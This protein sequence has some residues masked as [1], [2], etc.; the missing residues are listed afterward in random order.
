MEQEVD[1]A[2]TASPY[3]DGSNYYWVLI[4]LWPIESLIIWLAI[5]ILIMHNK[6]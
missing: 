1:K 4:I 6:K 5:I 3:P 2:T